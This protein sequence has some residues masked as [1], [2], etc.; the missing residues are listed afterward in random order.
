MITLIVLMTG[1]KVLY[2]TQMIVTAHGLV[3]L[4]AVYKLLLVLF[5]H[6]LLERSYTRMIP[7]PVLT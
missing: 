4:T 7:E 6:V 5:A 2:V 1:M 3:A